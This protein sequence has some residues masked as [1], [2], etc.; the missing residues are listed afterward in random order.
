MRL[1]HN[2]FFKENIKSL[3]WESLRNDESE[4]PYFIPFT[5]EK[6]LLRVGSDRPS[7]TSEE[8]IRE[9]ELSG[10]SKIF[11]IG[12][13]LA[14]QEYQLKKF[15]DISVFVSDFTPSILRLKSFKVFDDCFLINALTDEIPVDE[16]YLILFPRIDT[17]FDDHQ[18]KALFSKFHQLGIKRICFIPAQLLSFRIILSELKTR[19]LG[20][21]RRRPL[22][23]CGYTRSEKYFIKLWSPYYKISKKIQTDMVFFFLDNKNNSSYDRI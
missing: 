12:S 8:I 23:F 13:G 19:L 7:N 15:S 6:Y 3:D 18:L 16:S 5:L 1:R 14:S 9:M 17:E 22:V 2:G 21:I 4:T 10:Y 11:S 20:L